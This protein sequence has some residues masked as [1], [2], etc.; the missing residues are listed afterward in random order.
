MAVNVP[1]VPRTLRDAI[2]AFE[3][4]DFALEAF[5]EEVME[6]YVHFFKTEQSLF[7]RAV[8]DWERKR[9]FEQI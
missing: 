8:T 4:S 3:R 9:Y 7:D 5:S 6:H 2:T 1:Q